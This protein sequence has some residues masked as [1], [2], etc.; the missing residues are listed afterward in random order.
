MS[1]IPD[2]SI[3]DTSIL[4]VIPV[5]TSVQQQEFCMLAPSLNA[6][7]LDQGQADQHLLACVEGRAVA[8]CTLWWR[9][10]PFLQ[11]QRIG[12]IGHYAANDRVA[13][14]ELLAAAS[15]Q[16]AVRGCTLAVGPL[17][18][19]TFR[20]YRFVTRRSYQGDPYPPFLLEPDNPDAWPA[21]FGAA[22]FTP[23]SEYIS[24]LAPLLGPDPQLESLTTALAAQGIQL[25]SLDP[26]I[27][28][29][30][31]G[32]SVAFEKE[33]ARIYPLVMTAFATNPLFTPIS[34]VE[35]LAQF[36]PVRSLLSP[37]LVVL[38]ERA[39]ELVGFLFA[40]PDFAQAQRGEVI[41]T[42][43]LKTLAVLPSLAGMGLGS[44]L[45]AA[46]HTRAYHLGYRWAIHALMHVENRSRRISAHIAQ[47]FRGYTLFARPLTPARSL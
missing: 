28:D 43:I 1:I 14:A 34:Y 42:V 13:A 44:L 20:A 4:S 36:A 45:S 9:S 29:A 11:G 12:C 25:L 32:D 26:A 46:V 33:L 40:L 21:D 39:G 24:A 8:R 5:T 17:D 3:S 47:P 38:A 15:A 10:V 30:T 35:F 22:G 27:F 6:E 2:T 23:W 19:S 31:N 37:E 41:D 7:Q 16:L 18:G